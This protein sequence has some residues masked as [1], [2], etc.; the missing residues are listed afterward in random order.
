MKNLFKP[1]LLLA[2][3]GTFTFTSCTKENPEIHSADA[4]EEMAQLAEKY[5]TPDLPL[6][7]SRQVEAALGKLNGKKTELML[8]M[9]RDQDLKWFEKLRRNPV[10]EVVKQ[11]ADGSTKMVKERMTENQLADLRKEIDQ[12][13]ERKKQAHLVA[14]KEYGV[15][16]FQLEQEHQSKIMSKIMG[17]AYEPL[18][19]ASARTA[20]CAASAYCPRADC[21]LSAG[22]TVYWGI[23]VN[24]WSARIR[25]DDPNFNSIGQI[26]TAYVRNAID[27][28]DG[29]CDVIVGGIGNYKTVE[30]GNK[31]PT[32][33]NLLGYFGGNGA[34][35][36]RG[37]VYSPSGCNAY[38]YPLYLLWGATR[39]F[40]FYGSRDVLYL[41]ERMHIDIKYRKYN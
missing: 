9:L 30:V 26:Y 32:G 16:L 38:G 7:E 21:P 22:G 25:V 15:G 19:T 23:L 17:V 2:L 27:G 3:A 41:S 40:L 14:Q 11:Q 24:G 36:G 18:V 29:E 28:C 5:Y 8:E 13:Y 33:K 10:Q 39:L 37:Y 34:Y 31:T 1:L 20:D 6:E 35:L 12:V 4:R